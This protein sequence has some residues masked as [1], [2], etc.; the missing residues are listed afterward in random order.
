MRFYIFVAMTVVKGIDIPYLN[1]ALAKILRVVIVI[2]RS[3]TVDVIVVCLILMFAVVIFF[4]DL[5]DITFGWT[6]QGSFSSFVYLTKV[7][8]VL[9]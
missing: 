5:V 7:D 6:C 2:C 1:S 3:G 8:K 4:C 9:T